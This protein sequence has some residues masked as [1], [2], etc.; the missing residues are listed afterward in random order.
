MNPVKSIKKVLFENIWNEDYKI[1]LFWSRANGDFKKNSD[2]DIGIE[3]KKK[4]N[5]MQFLKLKR[6]LDELPFIIDLVDFKTV[7]SDFKKIALNKIERW[8]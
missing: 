4:M 7:D 5:L 3:W 6:K 8:N 2:Y 1:F